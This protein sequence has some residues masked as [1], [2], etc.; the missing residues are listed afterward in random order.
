[1]S[2]GPAHTRSKTIA[3]IDEVMPVNPEPSQTPQPSTGPVGT[4]RVLR[5]RL[6]PVVVAAVGAFVWGAA[7]WPHALRPLPLAGAVLTP[8]VAASGFHLPDQDGRVVS[9]SDL[10]GKVVALTFLYTHC[11]DVCPLIAEQMRA[12]YRQLGETARE[13]AFVAVSVDPAGDT[14]AAIRGFLRQH[15]V[16]GMLTYLHGSASQLRPIWARYYVGSDAGEVNPIAVA[17]A[18]PPRAT[19]D[20]TAIV[21]VIDPRGRVRVFLPGNFAPR[22]LVADI[23]ALAAGAEPV[24]KTR[25]APDQSK[26]LRPV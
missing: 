6:W 13:A 14:P 8:P 2:G 21:Y 24:R 5:R 15:R 17:A 16:E 11:P 19:V 12:A 9:L 10:R 22:D 1:M 25:P 3:I 23:R 7:A 4:P 18:A 26:P 20:H